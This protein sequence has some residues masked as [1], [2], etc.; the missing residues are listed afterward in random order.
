ML[1]PTLFSE[2]EGIEKPSRD[3]WDRAL[4]RAGFHASQ[5][6]H[7]GDEIAAYVRCGIR[8]TLAWIFARSDYHGAKS[9]GLYAL[10]LRRPEEPMEEEKEEDIQETILS[11]LEVP[12]LTDRF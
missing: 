6:M 9:A 4:S 1:S 10:L 2:E 3:I 12:P 11:L 7:V 8:Q 5:A